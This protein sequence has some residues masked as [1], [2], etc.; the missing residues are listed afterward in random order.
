[1]RFNSAW[2]CQELI[3]AHKSK[4]RCNPSVLKTADAI[5]W[6]LFNIINNYSSVLIEVP[7][8]L[9]SIADAALQSLDSDAAVRT[10]FVIIE[11]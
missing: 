8:G 6:L 1:M 9:L 7:T 10:T 5:F 2:V 4:Y 3:G 11:L